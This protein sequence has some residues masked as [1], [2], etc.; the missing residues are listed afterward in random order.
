MPVKKLNTILKNGE[1]SRFEFIIYYDNGEIRSSFE[2]FLGLNHNV[3]LS[4][5]SAYFSKKPYIVLFKDLRLHIIPYS[6]LSMIRFEYRNIYS[7]L[8]SNCVSIVF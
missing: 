4:N 1:K 8:S 5:Y 3:G 7:A 6:Y 2:A